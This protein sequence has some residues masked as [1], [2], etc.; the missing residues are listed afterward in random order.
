MKTA[1]KNLITLWIFLISSLVAQAQGIIQSIVP[2][3]G[4]KGQQMEL[5]VRAVGTQFSMSNTTVSLG[6]GITVNQIQVSNSFT[7]RL[8]ISIDAGATTGNRTLKV[9]SGNQLLELPDAFEVLSVGSNLQ[10]I[11][12]IV[13]VQ[14]LY[15]S[16]F[17]PNNP[18]LAPLLFK[19]TVMNDQVERNLKVVFSLLLEGEGLL[20]KAI[21]S[22]PATAPSAIVRVDNR[23]F[24][25]YEFSP[26]SVKV[27]NLVKTTGILPAGS[28]TYKIEIFDD[29]N[30]LL[31]QTEAQNYLLNQSTDIV[32]ISPG[33][34]M[35]L[36]PEVIANAQPLF[37]WISTA[38]QYD[39][40]LFKVDPGQ[41]NTQ[42]IIQNI[43]V[44]KQLGLSGNSLLYPIS[45]ELLESGKTYAWQIRAYTNTASGNLMVESPLYWFSYA[46]SNVH[47]LEIV[48]FKVIPEETDVSTG[49][50]MQF[51]VEALNAQGQLVTVLPVWKVAPVSEGNVTNTGLFKAGN[52]PKTVAV[53]A[54]YGGFKDYAVVNIKYQKTEA[55]AFDLLYQLFGNPNH[56]QQGGKK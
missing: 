22:L 12:E 23:Q 55:P 16:D 51:K 31:T 56:I 8:N 42:Q 3:S 44:Y 43:P 20:G 11:L 34:L 29:K 53:V 17:D 2:S 30:N 40:L 25:T 21:K 39:F 13:P 15:A 54:E 52:M 46:K 45:A 6:Q 9:M 26:S 49:Q 33:N 4:I 50:T 19:V 32:L 35:D 18:T 27:A 37:Q 28:Y 48:S 5:V 14:T 10:A 36:Q 1:V 7:L 41:I 47:Q 24:E 38:N